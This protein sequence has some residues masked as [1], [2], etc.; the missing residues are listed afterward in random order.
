MIPLN[1][2][3]RITGIITIILGLVIISSGIFVSISEQNTIGFTEDDTGDVYIIPD[4]D[5]PSNWIEIIDEVI[6][7]TY[8]IPTTIPTTVPTTTPTYETPIPDPIVFDAL[9]FE[10]IDEFTIECRFGFYYCEH[11]IK[12]AQISFSISGNQLVDENNTPV[13]FDCDKIG[14]RAF[15]TDFNWWSFPEGIIDVDITIKFDV[16]IDGVMIDELQNV[17]GFYDDKG[18]MTIPEHD[19][20]S[21]PDIIEYHKKQNTGKWLIL[22]GIAL[23]VIGIIIIR[24][25]RKVK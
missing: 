13:I 7:S 12:E 22:G 3:I 14:L 16:Y 2:K 15:R 19:G 24:I 17:I 4:P 5:D 11:D 1:N 23:A 6:V 18:K 25:A 20:E 8:T 9:V 10:L 21:P